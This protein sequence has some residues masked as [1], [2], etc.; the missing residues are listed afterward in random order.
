[1]NSSDIINSN[2]S[3]NSN[4]KINFVIRGR[5]GNAI[6]RYLASAILC[7]FYKG[8]Y[9]VCENQSNN[10]DDDYFL[11]ITNNLNKISNID[12]LNMTHYY[13]HDM[14]YKQ[15]KNLILEFI[16]QHP[17]HF[18]LTDGISAGDGKYEKFYMNDILN[19]PLLFNKKYKNVI[20]LRLEDFV[21][22]NIHIDVDRLITL[23]INLLEKNIL[24]EE[25][26]IVCMKPTTDFEEKYICKILELLQ[27][28][29]I[30]VIIESNDV[31]TDYYIMKEAELLIC[32]K[33]TLSWCASFLSDKIKTCY[34]PDYNAQSNMSC[35][36]PIDNTILY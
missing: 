9:V 1:M 13:Q 35:K 6:F 31:L 10:C 19:T 27:K 22:L 5:L 11:F 2:N 17:D 24:T 4:I 7:I 34:L 30:N 33:S 28:N 8:K 20:H 21:K 12:S 18:V 14:V 23:L 29:N 26:C 32:S 3:N 15:N 36:Y 25:L 16:R